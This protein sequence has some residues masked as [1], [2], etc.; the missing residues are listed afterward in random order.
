VEL[1]SQAASAKKLISSLLN[2]FD[3]AVIVERYLDGREFNVSLLQ[4]GDAVE[5]VAAA[6]IDFSAFSGELPRIVD[7][8]A[9]WN[10]ESFAYNNTPRVLGGDIDPHTLS[11]I[12]R[13]SL[14]AWKALG[15]LDYARVDIRTD[16]QGQ[17]FVLEVNPNPD[18]SPDG[19]FAAA[20]DFANIAYEEFVSVVLENAR[21]RLIHKGK[22]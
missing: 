3:S 7:Y 9:K 5:I 13:M 1:P 21:N 19:G 17:P 18:I 22:A 11:C 14:S 16:E 20:L 10:P 8:D 6:E 12:E 4:R 15:C 2:R